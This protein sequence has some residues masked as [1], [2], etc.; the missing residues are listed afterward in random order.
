M[1]EQVGVGMPADVDGTVR[2]SRAHVMAHIECA[3]S[4]AA[5]AVR[6]MHVRGLTLHLASG[7]QTYEL[8][9]YLR[10]MGI[11]ELIGRPYG[12]DLLGVNKTSR[13]YYERIVADAGV[14]PRDALVVDSH[15]RPLEW[16][17]AVG[18]RTVHVD[19]LRT[20]SRFTRIASLDELDAL[21][22]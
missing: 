7:G 21:L 22:D 5:P 1:C 3:Y 16:A 18:F 2:A 19:R 12:V 15:A 17:D 14:D 20:G 8:E 4:D 11:R 10:R 9:P 13:R 6:A